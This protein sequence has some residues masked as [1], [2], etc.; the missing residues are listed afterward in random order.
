MSSPFM[1][2]QRRRLA[3]EI[4]RYL[5]NGGLN[6][7]IGLSLIFF[8]MHVVRL[9]PQLSNFLAYA[10]TL[11]TSFFLHKRFTFKSKGA[12]HRELGLFFLVYWL[13]YFGNLTALSLLL[14]YHVVP[15]IAQIASSAVFVA[16]SFI[17][18]RVVIFSRKHEKIERENKQ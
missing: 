5:V 6:T 7:A 4:F 18:Q 9:S 14:R 15:G 16:I 17:L 8:F 2:P 12:V 11:F 13:S 10:I 1:T 3:G